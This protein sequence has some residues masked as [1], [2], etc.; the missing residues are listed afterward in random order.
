MRY[1]I[2]WTFKILFKVKYFRHYYFSFYK[3]LFKPFNLFKGVTTE[4]KYSDTL[5]IKADLEDWIQQN[6]F[7]TGAY[8]SKSVDFIKNTLDEGDTFIDIGANI[9]CFTLVGSQKVGGSGKV[10]AF[11][12]V[13]IVSKKLEQ[14]ISLNNLDNIILVKKAVMDRKIPVRLH[15]ARRDNLGMSSIQR[16]DAETGETIF[17]EAVTLDEY[18]DQENINDIKII[19]IDI[20]GAELPALKGMVHTLSKYKPIL[21]VEVSPEVTRSSKKRLQ[22]FDFLQQKSYDRY[23]VQSDGRL[24][25]PND[26]ELNDHTNFVFV[27]K[28]DFQ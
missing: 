5:K 4:C 22:V 27:Q 12:P 24:V 9:G 20:E 14:N 7:F 10:I 1:L 19:K 3:R 28:Q 17:V 23:I 8:D 16:H 18:L 13:D 21:V 25:H 15:L 6:I 11:E 2:A 26:R